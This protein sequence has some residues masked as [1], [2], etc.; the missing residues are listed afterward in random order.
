MKKALIFYSEDSLKP[1]GGPAGYL[2]NLNLGLQSVKSGELEITFFDKVPKKLRETVKK[3]DMIPKR[4]REFRRAVNDIRYEK[5]SYPVFEEMNDYDIIHFHSTD[6]MFLNREFLKNYKGKV[7]LT[8]HSPCVM[9]KE[10][11]EWLN[12]FD[13]KL[14]KKK[15][16]RIENI[17]IYGFERAD[18]IIFPCPE[19]EEPYF[20]T[21]ERYESIRDEKKLK[22][23]TTGIVGCK[24]KIDRNEFRKK[25]NIPDDAFVVSYAGRHNE[26]KGYADL[27]KIG[28]KL[29]ENENVYF[30]VAGLEEP[31]SGLDHKRW[32][33]V[34]WTNDPHSLIAAS[35]VFVLPNRE[36][37]FDL[38]LLEVISL[39]VPMV[40]SET[41]GNKYFKKYNSDAFMYY[42]TIEEAVS[43]LNAFREKP[44]P[45]RAECG[46]SAREVFDKDFTVKTFTDR[47]IEILTQIAQEG[48]DDN[49]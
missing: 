15:I 42:K 38:I 6:D 10:K 14:F 11:L 40:L 41:G 16:D 25:Y 4:V 39:G 12:P 45:E 34:G 48:L 2:Y 17:D 13:Y 36:T 3:K 9:Y 26:I 33:E 18:Y 30:L 47:Y 46:K 37:Y 31:I 32:I 21:W 5:K 24:P 8:S 27:K 43:V 7:V 29:L 1:A 20:N 19:A 35:D 28:A 23:M 44:L 49:K 22:Y